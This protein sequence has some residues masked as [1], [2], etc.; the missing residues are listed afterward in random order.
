MDPA[1]AIV[2]AIPDVICSPKER[3]PLKRLVSMYL[4]I[5]RVGAKAVARISTR[6]ESYSSWDRLRRSGDCGL[7]PDEHAV[8]TFLLARSQTANTL[9]TDFP[10]HES[11][12]RICGRNQYYLSRLDRACA[13]GFLRAV[14]TKGSKNSYLPRDGLLELDG[15]ARRT[16][17]E[18]SELFSGL[19]EWCC[20]APE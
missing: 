1:D 2:P 4:G 8:T 16:R 11:E 15:G 10:T 14:G 19:G 12:V 9:L 13:V 20:F 3:V 7:A 18:W 17:R 5:G 6:V